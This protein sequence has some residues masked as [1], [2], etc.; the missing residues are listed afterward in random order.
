VSATAA[1]PRATVIATN[2]DRRHG[3]R[4][5]V[6]SIEGSLASTVMV[7]GRLGVLR[8]LVTGCKVDVIP[9]GEGDGG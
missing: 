9:E 6:A 1:R 4:L 8:A 2:T 3:V 7:P 5:L